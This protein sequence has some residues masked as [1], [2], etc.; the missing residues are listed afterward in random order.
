MIAVTGAAIVWATLPAS[1]AGFS[2]SLASRLLTN[3]IRAGQQLPDVG[4][5]FISS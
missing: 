4:P 5:H 1:S 3:T 2:R